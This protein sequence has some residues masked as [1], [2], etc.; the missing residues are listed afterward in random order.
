MF[1]GHHLNRFDAVFVRISYDLYGIE[2]YE[3][4][5]LMKNSTKDFS[6]VPDE[7]IIAA[8]SIRKL[9]MNRLVDG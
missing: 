1:P 3:S 7:E 6:G 4:A 5:L 2:T 9:G 8:A